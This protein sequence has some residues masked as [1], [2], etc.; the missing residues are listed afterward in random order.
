M[1]TFCNHKAAIASY[2]Y[3]RACEGHM[4]TLFSIY[5]VLVFDPTH[6]PTLDEKPELNC[7]SLIWNMN[8]CFNIIA[9]MHSN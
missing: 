7:F 6:P 3:L 2:V 4:H 5:T 8:P 9:I 1:L